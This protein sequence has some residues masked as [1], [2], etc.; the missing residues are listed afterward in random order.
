VIK[1]A[2][3]STKQL[4][5]KSRTIFSTSLRS[6]ANKAAQKR[7]GKCVYARTR[8]LRRGEE[9][10]VVEGKVS[11]LLSQ[12][13]FDRV[14]ELLHQRSPDAIAP[15]RVNSSYLLSGLDYCAKCGGALQGGTAKSGKYRYYGCYN[16]LRKGDVICRSKLVGAE[17]IERAV[18]STLKERVLTEEHLLELLKLTNDELAKPAS[19]IDR[20]ITQLEKQLTDRQVRQDRLF[21]A[22]ES[23]STLPSDVAPRLRKLRDEIDSLQ[24]HVTSM[25]VQKGASGAQRSI[26]KSELD[27]YVSDLH[28]LLAEGSFFERR[29]FLKSF[30]KAVQVD[31][32]QVSMEYKL[33]LIKKPPFN[34][35]IL[36]VG[37]STC[38]IHKHGFNAYDE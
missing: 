23:G 18:V 38:G 5:L 17:R 13:D 31:F 21:E 15:K 19:H 37:N 1:R 36:S 14:Q 25:K 24:T 4:P 29:S 30:M 2:V 33:P 12:T 27:R 9:R 7:V 28:K 26:S 20:E 35:E 32:P 22:V 10:F 11:P 8:R 16:Q 6:E 3:R 34:M